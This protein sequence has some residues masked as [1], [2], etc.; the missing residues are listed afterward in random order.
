MFQERSCREKDGAKG[1]REGR[2]GGRREGGR[3]DR[4]QQP[5]HTYP[6]GQRQDVS[7]RIR[8]P[9]LPPSLPHFFSSQEGSGVGR[10]GGRSNEVGWLQRLGGREEDGR[11]IAPASLPLPPFLVL[12]LLLVL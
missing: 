5:K 9:T 4:H 2:E 6:S 8:T 11:V 12:V 1:G 7:G 3:E 10:E